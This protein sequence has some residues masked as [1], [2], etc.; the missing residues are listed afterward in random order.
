MSWQI[1]HLA[2]P[3]EWWWRKQSQ[4][5]RAVVEEVVVVGGAPGGAGVLPEM[6]MLKMAGQLAMIRRMSPPILPQPE[7]GE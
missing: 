1:S 6:L 2:R 3:G 5:L 7:S 4:R